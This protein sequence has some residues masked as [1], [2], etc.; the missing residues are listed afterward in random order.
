MIHQGG[1]NWCDMVVLEEV[2]EA[3]IERLSDNFLR[4]DD[5]LEMEHDEEIAQISK[6]LLKVTDG[7]KIRVHFNDEANQLWLNYELQKKREA[8]RLPSNDL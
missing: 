6:M 2:D 3:S 1:P 8:V 4:Q 5:S 7:K